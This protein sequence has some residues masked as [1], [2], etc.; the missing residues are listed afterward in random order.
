MNDSYIPFD[1][2]VEAV[3]QVMDGSPIHEIAYRY[4][5]TYNHLFLLVNGVR[6]PRVFDQAFK[7][8]NEYRKLQIAEMADLAAR[9][10]HPSENRLNSMP[11]NPL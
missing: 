9:Q 6:R 7:R 2:S 5:M 8:Y 3:L 11:A 4:H 1:L 10:H